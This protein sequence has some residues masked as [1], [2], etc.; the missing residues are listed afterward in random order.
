[1]TV[2]DNFFVSTRTAIKQ[3]REGVVY[4]WVNH[5]ILFSSNYQ[6]SSC[7]IILVAIVAGVKLKE[8]MVAW[9]VYMIWG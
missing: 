1:M 6:I 8:S 5:A 7:E 3:G 9:G 4:G 2:W